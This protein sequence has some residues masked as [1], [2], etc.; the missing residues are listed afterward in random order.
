MALSFVFMRF[1]LVWDLFSVHA[2]RVLK[3]ETANGVVFNAILKKK[4]ELLDG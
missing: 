3:D 1:F 4:C 2:N